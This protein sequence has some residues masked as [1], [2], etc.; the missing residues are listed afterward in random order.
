MLKGWVESRFGICPSY[1]KVVIEGDSTAAWTTY[2]EEKMSSR[3]HNNAIWV[4]LD[5]LFEFCQWAIGR[6]AFP[7]KRM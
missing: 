7:G 1:H 5:L 6:F 4:Q 2:V 3:F